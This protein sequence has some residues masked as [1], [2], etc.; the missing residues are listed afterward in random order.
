MVQAIEASLRRLKT[1]SIDLYWLHA[2]DFTTPVDEVMRGLDDL[3]RAGKILYVGVSDTPAWKI[4]QANTMAELRGWSRFVALQVEYS[5]ARRD[6]ERDLAPMARELGLAIL[7]WSPLAGGVLTG[8]Y[9]PA[10]LEAQRRQQESGET[11]DPF[12]TSR[13]LVRLSERMLILADTVR[14]IAEEA[15]RTPAQVAINWLLTRP[16]VVSPILGARN[17]DQMKDNL[18]ALEFSL[19]KAHVERLDEVSAI[20]LGFPHDFLAGPFVREIIHGGCETETR[21]P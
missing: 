19:D 1:D 5:L 15:A 16:G 6:V 11:V 4:A 10:D 3:V 21:C 14:R 2:W 8:K 13:R 20:E 18:G 9:T 12:A 7:P 17:I